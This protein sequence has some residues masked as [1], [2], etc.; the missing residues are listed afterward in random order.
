LAT[1]FAFQKRKRDQTQTTAKKLPNEK[2]NT[3]YLQEAAIAGLLCNVCMTE[4]FFCGQVL[5]FQG[6]FNILYEPAG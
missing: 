6:K 5:A 1:G 3:Q 2:N 4:R